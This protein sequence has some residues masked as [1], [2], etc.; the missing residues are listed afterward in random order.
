LTFRVVNV[1]ALKAKAD[2]VIID[3]GPSSGIINKVIV[4]GSDYI[5]PAT[6]ADFNSI[7]SGEGLLTAVLPNWYTWYRDFL[8]YQK[9]SFADD[10]EWIDTYAKDFTRG[11]CMPGRLPRI[12]PFLVGAV[13]LKRNK[14]P[15]YPSALIIRLEDLIDKAKKTNDIL[16]ERFIS[17]N[18]G[19]HVMALV[20][21][22]NEYFTMKV[23]FV[24]FD[25][26][27]AEN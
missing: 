7:C 25:Q 12:L 14:V 8:K 18:N 13:R 10:E 21:E 1:A 27:S 3:V 26:C 24:L 11:F 15:Q 5:L 2:I 22:V 4:M 23:L 19:K 20:V 17:C 6:L 9:D 16:R